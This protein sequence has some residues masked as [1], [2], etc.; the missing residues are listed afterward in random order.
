MLVSGASI[1]LVS[2]LIGEIST[3]RSYGK[4]IVDHDFKNA[5]H[6][7]VVCVYIYI[8]LYMYT[9]VYIN[10]FFFSTTMRLM[11]VPCMCVRRFGAWLI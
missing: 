1:R 11:Q 5:H 9:Y 4:V 3:H 10:I 2:V 7:Y 6:M 8:Y